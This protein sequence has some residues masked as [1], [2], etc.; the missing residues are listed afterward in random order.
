MARGG[1]LVLLAGLAPA[2]PGSPL[3]AQGVLLEGRVEVD[4]PG[5]PGLL[6]VFLEYD[7][8]PEPGT[9]EVELTLLAPGATRLEAPD[10]GWGESD[11]ALRLSEIRPRYWTGTLSLPGG[12]A[13]SLTLRI[14][15]RV[16]ESWEEGGR[17]VLPL[18]VPAWAPQEP[19]PRTFVAGIHVPPGLTV[20]ESFPTS[21][22]MR[23]DG[24]EG[25]RYEVALQ[26]VPAMLVLR[27][28]Q[29]EAP[30]LT[31][32]RVLDILVVGALLIMGALGIRYLRGAG[33]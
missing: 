17:I 18:L 5:A 9:R 32:E 8:R 12:R 24:A 19:H 21:V 2:F 16:A 1:L 28:V 27:V 13:D 29:G 15:Y 14:S 3:E 7:L 25:G 26:G 6:P 22:V 10:L 4:L 31:L 23:P 33:G 30:F 11:L 20:T